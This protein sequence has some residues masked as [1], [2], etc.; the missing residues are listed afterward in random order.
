M[1][2]RIAVLALK[3]G[4]VEAAKAAFRRALQL[5]PRDPGPLEAMARITY[6]QGAFAESAAYYERSLEAAPDAGTA[7]TLGS[8]R[9]E[10]LGA[11][12][13]A[14]FATCAC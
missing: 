6:R 9:L 1:E 11:K 7:R 2:T 5:H 8:I 13:I 10:K 3:K 14:S 4:E 12:R